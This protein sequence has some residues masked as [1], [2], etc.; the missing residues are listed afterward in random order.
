MPLGGGAALMIVPVLRD[1]GRPAK[2]NVSLDA[3]MLEAIDDAAREHGLSRSAFIASATREK[4][5]RGT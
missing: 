4:I 3:G 1:A 5:E 2:A